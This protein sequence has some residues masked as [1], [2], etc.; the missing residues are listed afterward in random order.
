MA[1]TTSPSSLLLQV[2]FYLE[3]ETSME[4]S[5]FLRDMPLTLREWHA[6][7]TIRA[8]VRGNRREILPESMNGSCVSFL[9]L[10]CLAGC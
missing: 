4:T 3:G 10:V 2:T 9:G 7:Q 5:A 1:I 8:R 6:T